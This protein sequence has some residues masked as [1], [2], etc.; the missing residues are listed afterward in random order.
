MSFHNT[1]GTLHKT[2]T[3]THKSVYPEAAVQQDTTHA[4]A[5]YTEFNF[6][7]SSFINTG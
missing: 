2:H 4:P 3:Q 1:R 5:A 6:E 7:M